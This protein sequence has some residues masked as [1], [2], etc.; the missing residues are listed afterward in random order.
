M[1]ENGNVW[2]FDKIAECA[3]YSGKY[4]PRDHWKAGCDQIGDSR[5]VRR[6]TYFV[7]G[8][9][10]YRQNNVSKVISKIDQCGVWA[11]SIYA[12]SPPLDL[13]GQNVYHQ[14]EEQFVFV[15]DRSFVMCCW[16]MK[17]TVQHRERSRV[18]WNV[19]KK[20]R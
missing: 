7:G 11:D 4:G 15:R 9:A 20:N 5:A 16:Q 18:C 13:T 19:W 8:Y 2:T 17:L 14:K 1:M 10:G 12:G 3:G 6:G